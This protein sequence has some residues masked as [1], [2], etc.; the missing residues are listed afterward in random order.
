MS[1]HDA[2]Y[3][4]GPVEVAH[5][6]LFRTWKRFES[7]LEP[8]RARLEALRALQVD[9]G[10]WERNGKNE[11]FLNHRANR[12]AEARGLSKNAG[13]AKRLIGRDF[14]YFTA[15]E[16]AEGLARRRKRRGKVLVACLVG[17]AALTGVALIASFIVLSDLGWIAKEHYQRLMAMGPSGLTAEEEKE[18]AAKPGPDSAFAEC[19]KDCPV[20]VVVPKGKFLIGSLENE[21]N[22][23]PMEGPE[24]EVTIADPFGVSK[25]EVTFAEWDAC[26]DAGTCQRVADLWGRGQMPAINVSWEDAKQYVR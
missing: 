18:K 7:W 11:G 23:T 13:Y 3:G 8:E 25:F 17:L 9:S 24:H 10:N 16:A 21:R 1:A 20:M 12:L 14:A 26:V 4:G 19:K 6:A 15:C 2:H 22:R 5:E